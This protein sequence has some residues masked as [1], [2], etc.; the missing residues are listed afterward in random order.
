MAGSLLVP[1]NSVYPTVGTD[2]ILKAFI[3]V[4]AGGLGN[5]RGAALVAFF[6]GEVQA[7]GS[8]VVRPVDVEL[9]LFALVI[10]LLIVRSRRQSAL[11]RL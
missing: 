10:I 6:L 1:L 4:V 2:V 3:V 5:F 11:V 7:L 9:V 8:I